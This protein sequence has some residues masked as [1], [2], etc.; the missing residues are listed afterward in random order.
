M[1]F[2]AQLSAFCIMTA[3]IKA[4]LKMR[5]I[6]KKHDN[7]LQTIINEAVEGNKDPTYYAQKNSSI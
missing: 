3:F 4:Y 1:S 7:L 6:K 2:S 5:E